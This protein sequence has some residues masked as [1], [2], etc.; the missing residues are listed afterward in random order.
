VADIAKRGFDTLEGRT[1]RNSR[2][3][4]IAAVDTCLT[5]DALDCVPYLVAPM[6]DSR[7]TAHK[8]RTIINGG[9]E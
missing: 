6:H 4:L 5:H 2:A 3:E 1:I 7:M 8:G 9:K